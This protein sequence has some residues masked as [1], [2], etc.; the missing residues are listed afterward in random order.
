MVFC[1]FAMVASS[2]A[3]VVSHVGLHATDVGLHVAYFSGNGAHIFLL[4][5]RLGFNARRCELLL[6]LQLGRTR[7]QFFLGHTQLL[8]QSLRIGF[9]GLHALGQIADLLLAGGLILRDLLQLAV[10]VVNEKCRCTDVD[11][12]QRDENPFPDIALRL[13]VVNG[14]FAFRHKRLISS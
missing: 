6:M 5:L 10:L 11:N 7:G 13:G 4:F 8:R 14:R 1:S 3:L 12:R 9:R 2:D